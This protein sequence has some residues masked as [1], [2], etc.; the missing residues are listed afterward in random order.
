MRWHKLIR[1]EKD[2]VNLAA[3]INAAVAVNHGGSGSTNKVESVSQVRVVQ[4]SRRRAA[5]SSGAQTPNHEQE[6]PND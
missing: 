5:N 2:C 3:D 4:D 1:L 6:V